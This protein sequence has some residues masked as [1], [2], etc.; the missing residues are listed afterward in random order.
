MDY[1]TELPCH[2]SVLTRMNIENI[3]IDDIENWWVAK[4][5]INRVLG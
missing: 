5:K 1:K 3:T 2:M 4:D